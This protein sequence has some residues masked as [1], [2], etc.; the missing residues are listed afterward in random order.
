MG[1]EALFL[2]IGPESGDVTQGA[3][4]PNIGLDLGQLFR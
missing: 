1:D 3:Q 2:D 4:F